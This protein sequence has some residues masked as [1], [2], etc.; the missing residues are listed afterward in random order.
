MNTYHLEG[1]FDDKTDT[2][3]LLLTQ[4]IRACGWECMISDSARCYVDPMRT[5]HTFSRQRNKWVSGTIDFMLES[6]LST[7]YSRILWLQEGNLFINFVIRIMFVV[8]F[9]IAVLTNQFVWNWIWISP[10]VA[11]S[12]LNV[13][14][15]VKT[16]NHRF[17]DIILAG[18]LINPELYLWA[19]LGVH[20]NVWLSRFRV[21]KKDGWAMQ[22]A[23]EAGQTHSKLVLHMLFVLAVIAAVSLLI[24]YN[25]DYIAS[26]GVREALEPY[27]E[28][29]FVILTILTIF[30]FFVMLIQIWR[31]RAPFKA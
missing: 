31:L 23:A 5:L 11:A 28:Q 17:I 21:S 4:Y 1:V 9:S 18:T 30:E 8:L 24:R 12:I 26:D 10:I 27:L 19:S 25:Y 7:K 6:G 29:G 3:D 15:T 16:P 13:I 22:Y 14:L 2:E 20:T